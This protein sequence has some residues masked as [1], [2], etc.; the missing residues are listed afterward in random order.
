[1]TMSGFSS[2]RQ[3]RR[4]AGSPPGFIGTVNPADHEEVGIP[5][6]LPAFEVLAWTASVGTLLF[7]RACGLNMG[8]HALAFTT[9]TLVVETGVNLLMWGI[10]L[11]L[12]YRLVT[13]RSVKSYFRMLFTPEWLLLMLRAWLACVAVFSAYVWL[14]VSVPLIN[15]ARWD[16][17]LWKLDRTLHGGYS[18]NL[19]LLDLFEGSRAAAWIDVWYGMWLTTAMAGSFFFICFAGS[20]FRQRFVLSFVATWILGAWWYLAL[21]AVGPVFVF[22]EVQDSVRGFLPTA[23]QIQRSLAENYRI[24]V[25]GR[26]QELLPFDPMRGVA[27]LPSLHVGMHWLL[28]LWAR[29]LAPWLFIPF[30]VGTLVTL[31]GSIL[32]GW[33]YAVDGY[34]GILLAYAC[35]RAALATD[36]PASTAAEEAR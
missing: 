24:I 20:R 9:P 35:Y 31:V 15:Y 34:A 16:D 12:I 17:F 19:V 2:D 6:R 30:A 29:R 1:M 36:R 25:A 7:L 10:P 11:H 27:A 5:R 23:E 32:T 3:E 18:P 14:K 13:R 28:T 33:H 8:W 22:P 21:P 26:T 4:T